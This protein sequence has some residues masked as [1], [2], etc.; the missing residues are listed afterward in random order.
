[1]F[2][3]GYKFTYKY[4]FFLSTLELKFTGISNMM[5]KLDN[6]SRQSEIKNLQIEYNDILE[7]DFQD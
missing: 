5:N 2:V 3:L 7:G 6:N 1:M 4:P